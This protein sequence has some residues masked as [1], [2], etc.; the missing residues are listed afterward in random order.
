MNFSSNH[1]KIALLFFIISTNIYSSENLKFN[2]S[3]KVYSFL[4]SHEFQEELSSSDTKQSYFLE[5]LEQIKN[6]PE[7]YNDENKN[8]VT[9]THPFF[10]KIFAIMDENIGW[11][12]LHHLNLT[13]EKLNLL[14]CQANDEIDKGIL[15]E[16]Q[17]NYEASFK[18][19]IESLSPEELIK[20]KHT[21]VVSAS[22]MFYDMIKA[23]VPVKLNSSDNVLVVSKEMLGT[24]GKNALI[25][26]VTSMY[27]S[28]I[29]GICQKP[30][31]EIFWFSHHSTSVHRNCY[32]LI[33]I[34]EDDSTKTIIESFHQQDWHKIRL[35]LHNKV[36]E[37]CGGNTILD[38]VT[39]NG[40]D[41]LKKI[42]DDV[43]N[44]S[45][46]DYLQQEHSKL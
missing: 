37:A 20:I 5:I 43:A 38:F 30:G 33:K 10:S 32:N 46:K 4:Q 39:K 9:I 34:A 2:L 22:S 17:Q 19:K 26:N 14:A 35:F 36:E 24:S 23:I 11:N 42:Y 15:K 13:Q 31:P 21:A 28:Q 27:D 29:C 3:S 16:M 18:K 6:D 45:L 41:A 44:T 7:I 25:D 12:L 1:Y 40:K 8:M